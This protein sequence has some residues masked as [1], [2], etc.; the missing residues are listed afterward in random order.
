V[1]FLIS[2]F[3]HQVGYFD[4]DRIMNNKGRVKITQSR[5]LNPLSNKA[6]PFYYNVTEG[7]LK[8]WNFEKTGNR[9]HQG[10][11]A[12]DTDWQSSNPGAQDDP[13][14]FNIDRNSFYNIEGHQGMDYQKALEQIK[15]I[16]D[17]QQLDLILWLSLEELVHNKDFSKAYFN[18]YVEQNPEWNIGMEWKREEPF[19]RL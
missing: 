1:K 11:L 17:K 3:N 7:F 13:L 9:S 14:V 2:R 8:A 12:Y 18:E 19:N 6:I 5:K 4:A 10:N 15:Q 16:R